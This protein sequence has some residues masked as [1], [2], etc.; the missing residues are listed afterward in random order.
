VNKHLDFWPVFALPTLRC[1]S[2]KSSRGSAG[3]EAAART[4]ASSILLLSSGGELLPSDVPFRS[5]A[6]VL[7]CRGPALWVLDLLQPRFGF[8][9]MK[10][11]L[12]VLL[13]VLGSVRGDQIIEL[14]FEGSCLD[15]LAKEPKYRVD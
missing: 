1:S 11:L 12:F 6:R 4:A 10:Y 8:V 5:K 7:L 15:F 14:G 9:V 13:R 3:D 2:F